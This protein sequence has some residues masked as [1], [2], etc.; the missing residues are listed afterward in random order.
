MSHER[1][2]Q[3][4]ELYIKAKECI[5]KDTL[6]TETFKAIMEVFSPDNDKIK[7][8]ETYE[9]I[10]NEL[11]FAGFEL[12]YTF[13]KDA[14][15]KA[16]QALTFL[17]P[18]KLKS[19]PSTTSFSAGKDNFSITFSAK[20]E[21]PNNAKGKQLEQFLTYD[22]FRAVSLNAVRIGLYQGVENNEQEM[23]KLPGSYFDKL[24]NEKL[25]IATER[26][27]VPFDESINELIRSNLTDNDMDTIAKFDQRS[28][29]LAKELSI[30]IAPKPKVTQ[31]VEQQEEPR[32]SP[33]YG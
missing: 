10:D 29:V 9:G 32:Q 14:N 11:P 4:A 26:T 23:V 28:G 6:T 15:I 13:P 7:F 25:L 2:E 21:L 19:I 17:L 24:D 30:A 12:E 3:V 33:R 22:I 8:R 27:K 18:D 31:Q 1:I 5:A 16:I 20:Q